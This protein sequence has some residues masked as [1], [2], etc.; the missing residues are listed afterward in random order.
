MNAETCI[1]GMSFRSVVGSVLY[2]ALCTRPDVSTAVA[3]LARDCAKPGKQHVDALKRLVG[4]LNHTSE[5]GIIYHRQESGPTPPTVIEAASPVE[6]PSLTSFSDANY[7][8]SHDR[9]STSGYVVLLNE[10]PVVWSSKLQKIT[11]QST[12]ESEC[13]AATECVKEVA[14]IRLLLS[15]LGYGDLV[16]GPTGPI[17]S[18]ISMFSC[19]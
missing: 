15:E 17:A 5:L 3:I 6:D 9:K 19:T 13:I 8:M 1:N 14:H 4:Y 12:A 10:G 16:S 7:A 2:L 11:S 18:R